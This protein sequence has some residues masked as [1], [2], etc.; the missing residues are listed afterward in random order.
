MSQI[1]SSGSGDNFVFAVVEQ[2]KILK[3][4]NGDWIV[5][6]TYEPI[7]DM[8]KSVG[9]DPADYR[10]YK[11][12]SADTYFNSTD[13][14]LLFYECYEKAS[15]DRKYAL[16]KYNYNDRD[17]K[18]RVVGATADILNIQYNSAVSF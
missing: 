8:V 7:I 5:L 12:R 2:F 14:L 16:L 6:E 13:S 11:L 1:L 15:G 10:D 17:T 18:F 9:D 3:I 4:K